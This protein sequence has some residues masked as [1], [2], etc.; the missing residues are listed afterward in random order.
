MSIDAATYKIDKLP[1]LL[2]IFYEEIVKIRI[3]QSIWKVVMFWDTTMT[4]FDPNY[5][6]NSLPEIS[7]N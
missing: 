5:Y 4:K 7:N 6:L 1:G 3:V 2:V